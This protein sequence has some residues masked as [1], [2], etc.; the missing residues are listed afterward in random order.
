MAKQAKQ[1]MIRQIKSTVGHTKHTKACMRGLGLRKINHCVTREDT[2]N[3]RG[4]I[5]K[6]SFLLH[7]EEA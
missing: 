6:V 7:V 5:N 1:L 4:L 3:T 2:P